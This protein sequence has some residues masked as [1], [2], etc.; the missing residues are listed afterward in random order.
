MN[1]FL[2]ILWVLAYHDWKTK[3]L[4]VNF[5]N[6]LSFEEMSKIQNAFAENRTSFPLMAIFTPYNKSSSFWTKKEPIGPIFSRLIKLAQA[7]YITFHQQLDN[8]FKSDFMV[9]INHQ[10]DCQFYLSSF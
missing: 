3:P 9:T 1:G 2:K 5:N 6:I 8:I 7:T 10:T 4:I